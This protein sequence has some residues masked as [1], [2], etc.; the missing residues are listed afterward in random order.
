MLG[1]CYS[2]LCTEFVLD[3]DHEHMRY[4]HMT[5][6]FGASCI[7]VDTVSEATELR[8]LMAKSKVPNSTILSA[9]GHRISS[10]GMIGSRN[11]IPPNFTSIV[12]SPCVCMVVMVVVVATVA[13]AGK[14]MTC[15][16]VCVDCLLACLLACLIA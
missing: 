16:C 3:K 15:L 14:I 10:S 2:Y 4:K 13:M 6:L 9:D 5:A 7:L 8:R 12:G 11:S 1:C